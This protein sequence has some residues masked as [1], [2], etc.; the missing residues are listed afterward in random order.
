MLGNEHSRD[1]WW[2]GETRQTS[3]E[4]VAVGRGESMTC[5]P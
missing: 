3:E 5:S 2:G 1:D 4:A